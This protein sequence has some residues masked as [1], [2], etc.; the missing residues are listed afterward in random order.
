MLLKQNE[1]KI[2]F[3][4]HNKNTVVTNA[5]RKHTFTNNITLSCEES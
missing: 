5:K 3:D 1:E 4:N 2:I